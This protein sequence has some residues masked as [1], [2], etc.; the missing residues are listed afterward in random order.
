MSS[1]T[2]MSRRRRARG[3]RGAAAVE[4]ALILVVLAPL[5]LGTLQYGYYFYVAQSASSAAR[6]TARR[7]AVGDCRVGTEANDYAQRQANLRGLVLTYGTTTAQAA[8]GPAPDVGE[9]MRVRLQANGKIVG[10]LP[11][12]ADGQ[13]DRV[14]DVLVEDDEV[15]ATC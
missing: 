13:I 11:L 1:R 8:T 2:V 3:E 5:L 4:F 14:V 9:V 12:P 10:Y 15:G 6:E 7:L